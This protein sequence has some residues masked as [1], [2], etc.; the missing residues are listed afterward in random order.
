MFNQVYYNTFC[1]RVSVYHFTHTVV[2]MPVKFAITKLTPQQISPPRHV[3]QFEKCWY[4]GITAHRIVNL[5]KC[6]SAVIQS[7]PYAPCRDWRGFV[8]KSRVGIMWSEASV[9]KIQV[10]LTAVRFSPWVRNSSPLT[11]RIRI[12]DKITAAQK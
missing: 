3:S 6:P 9:N 11:P 12:L 2:G 1:S 10:S 7:S 4:K 5:L 8:C